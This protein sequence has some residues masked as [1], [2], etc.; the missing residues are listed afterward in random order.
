MATPRRQRGSRSFGL[1]PG[2]ST[3][4]LQRVFSDIDYAAGELPELVN[5]GDIHVR[6]DK[7]FAVDGAETIQTTFRLSGL[8]EILY[9]REQTVL[10]PELV[11]TVP[12]AFVPYTIELQ[13]LDAGGAV[14]AGTEEEAIVTL[15][16]DVHFDPSCGASGGITF[17]GDLGVME[18]N[19]AYVVELPVGFAANPTTEP[20]SLGVLIFAREADDIRVCDEEYQ[21]SGAHY[22]RVFVAAVGEL[23]PGVYPL[24]TWT[25]GDIDIAL[26]SAVPDTFF[27]QFGEGFAACS[28]P[29][30][31]CECPH[32][33]PHGFTDGELV[34]SEVS[35]AFVGHVTMGT[36]Q[37]DFSIPSCPKTLEQ[38]LA[39]VHDELACVP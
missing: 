19:D 23:K 27:A 17:P 15:G 26:A 33:S 32:A 25:E 34:L 4:A 5:S 24:E 1:A 39:I 9:V 21:Q 14:I 38:H 11:V 18:S 36:L 3:R 20:L 2:A 35:G 10:T 13:V 29:G 31:N 8:D 30:P 37:G 6:P 22:L 16:G 12:F 7:C 28:E